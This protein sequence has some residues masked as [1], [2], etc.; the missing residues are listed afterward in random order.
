MILPA[1]SYSLGYG[2]DQR[3]AASGPV[4]L[5]SEFGPLRQF[6]LAHPKLLILEVRRFWPLL[7]VYIGTVV[8]AVGMWESLQRISKGGGKGG[9]P[10]FGFPGFPRTVIST[11]FR[12]QC[13]LAPFFCFSAVRRKR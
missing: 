4:R 6:N 3:E 1:R 10:A 12:C 13:A 2:A 7:I 11:A 8:E 5:A 9:K